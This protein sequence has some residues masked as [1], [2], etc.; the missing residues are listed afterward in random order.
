MGGSTRLAAK[1]VLVVGLVIAGRG[2][3]SGP[4]QPD[5]SANGVY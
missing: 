2:L 1:V 5:T 3:G 4:P